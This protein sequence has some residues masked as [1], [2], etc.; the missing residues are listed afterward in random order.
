MTTSGQNG[1]AATVRRIAVIAVHGCPM[2]TPGMR[3]AGGMNVNLRTL[4]PLLAKE[5]VCVDIYTRSHEDG[6]PQIV[7]LAP[8][9]RVIH[10]PAGPAH[11][12]K[13][14]M[15][16]HMPQFLQGLLAYR[17]EE[18]LGYDLVHSHYWLSAVVGRQ[19]ALAWGVPH[20]VTFHTVGLVKEAAHGE[21]E[22]PERIAAE[23]EAATTAD[24][25]FVF[26]QDEAETM[27]EMY[28]LPASR[29]HVAPGGV[30][31]DLFHPRDRAAARAR[32]GEPADGPL[33]LY[34]GRLDPFKG[35]E[36]L[37]LALAGMNLAPRLVL[38]GGTKGEAEGT[39]LL[40]LARAVGVAERV[41]W[42]PAVPQAHLADY[43]AA[44]DV[45]AMPSLHE[46]FG[47]V[48]LE[49][50]ATGVPV[51]TADAGALRSLV[52][53]GR[54]GLLVRDHEPVAYA[55]ALE[56]LLADG[57]A[58]RRM[59]AAARAWASTFR[60]ERAAH[61]LIDGYAAVLAERVERPVVTPCAG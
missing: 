14:Q 41:R 42:Q 16:Q 22:P 61:R 39:R 5:G 19:A 54:T 29:L 4:T 33:V 56:T 11:V 2:M 55:R 60:W 35:P 32:I 3:S 20:V 17:L 21:A 36:L 53:D 13:E 49:A 30:N 40:D 9:V 51:V 12:T 44:A 58:R 59:G 34:A 46:T 24:R 23:Y 45:V 1:P 52:Q 47:L 48:A 15:A 25:I 50:M 18:D 37:V 27:E 31:L 38:V 26:T 10:I 8:H 57:D 43:F 7:D 6:G 28:E